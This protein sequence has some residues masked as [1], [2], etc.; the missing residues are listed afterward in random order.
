MGRGRSGYWAGL[1]RPLSRC[2]T[3]AGALDGECGH[4]HYK[5]SAAVACLLRRLQTCP[6]SD[7][8]VMNSDRPFPPTP[9]PVACDTATRRLC[10]ID[11]TG[12]MWER[13]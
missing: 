13:D 1:E 5:V 10:T 12:R 4:R 11:E 7:R 6:T 9:Y 8:T 3:T 2:W